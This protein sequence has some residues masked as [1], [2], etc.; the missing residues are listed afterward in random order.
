MYVTRKAGIIR[1]R[2]CLFNSRREMQEQNY[3]NYSR[4][5]VPLRREIISPGPA[6]SLIKYSRA[7]EIKTR[8]TPDLTGQSGIYFGYLTG[9]ND[10]LIIREEIN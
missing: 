10:R 4:A 8:S 6:R 2:A 3:E 7:S 5:P 9:S 1:G